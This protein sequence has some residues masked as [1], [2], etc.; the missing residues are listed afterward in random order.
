MTTF[1]VGPTA[2][3]HTIAAAMLAAGA[4]DSIVLQS[5]YSNETATVTH[6]GMTLSG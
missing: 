3:F 6:V 1:A 4:S 2:P 5:G